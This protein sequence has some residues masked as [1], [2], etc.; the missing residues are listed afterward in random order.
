MNEILRPKVTETTRNVIKQRNELIELLKETRGDEAY[1]IVQ[2]A[3]FDYGKRIAAK[4]PELSQKTEAFH[5]LIGSGLPFNRETISDFPDPEDRVEKFLVD[6]RK[7]F[8][9]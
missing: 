1:L 6:L 4:Y 3:I 2:N 7:R 8:L 9:H 5:A